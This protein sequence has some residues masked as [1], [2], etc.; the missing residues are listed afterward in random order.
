MLER[1]EALDFI[2]TLHK[3]RHWVGYTD[4]SVKNNLAGAGFA[5]YQGQHLIHE[6]SLSLGNTTTIFQAELLAILHLCRFISSFKPKDSSD[7]HICVD[8]KAALSAISA[9]FAKSHTVIDTVSALNILGQNH[10]V[11]LHWAPAHS[12]IPGN[13]L[14]D[15][16]ANTG[17]YSAP[18]GPPPF[19]PYS[20]SS[21]NTSVATHFKNLFLSRIKLFKTDYDFHHKNI[22]NLMNNGVNAIRKSKDDTRILTHLYTG[23]SYLNFFQ[24]KIG[25]EHSSKCDKCE[26]ED[27]TTSHFLTRCP[28]YALLRKNVFGNFIINE[29]S[30]HTLAFPGQIL[31]YAH[32]AKYLE[33]FEPP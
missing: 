21:V 24:H 26:E 1:T 5:V 15:R 9:T 25:N 33:F 11:T 27:E 17:S 10:T 19:S 12:N 22:L 31:N 29:S 6:Y 13:E 4:G 28:A 7:V 20:A 23:C 14:A 8:S 32:K 18:I 30:F 3:A 16:L 2:P